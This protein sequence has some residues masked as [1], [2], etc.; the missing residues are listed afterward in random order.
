MVI[1]K[2]QDKGNGKFTGVLG[3]EVSFGCMELFYDGKTYKHIGTGEDGSLLYSA[4]ITVDDYLLINKQD[5]SIIMIEFA[6]S[7]IVHYARN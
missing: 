3:A 6:L 4:G 7:A 5:D 2:L 1:H